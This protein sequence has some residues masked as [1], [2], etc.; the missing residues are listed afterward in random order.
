MSEPSQP[1]EGIVG[2]GERLLVRQRLLVSEAVE[3]QGSGVFDTDLN[4][5]IGRAQM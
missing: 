2:R 5:Q 1:P 4:R 3:F